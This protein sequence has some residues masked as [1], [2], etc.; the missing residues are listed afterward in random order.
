MIEELLPDAVVTVE[1]YGDEEP[2]NTALY[3]EEEA[4]VAQAV[5]KRRREFAVVR[6]CAR[7]AMEK[8]GVPPQ[9][10]LP[11]ERGAPGWP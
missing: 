6:S 8:L 11:G 7:R 10:I 4:V 1:A 3:P 9:P 5:G 2:P